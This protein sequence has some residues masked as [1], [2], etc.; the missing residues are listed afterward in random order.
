MRRLWPCWPGLLALLG[1]TALA[2]VAGEEPA[3][4]QLDDLSVNARQ[5]PEKAGEVPIAISVIE[6]RQLDEAGLTR[7][8]ELPERVPGLS[9]AAPN[10]RQASYAIRGLGSS[11]Y[12]DGLDGSVGVFVDGVYLG[13]PGMSL[14]TLF[15]LERVEVLRGPQ[16]TLYGKNSTAGTLNLYSRLPTFHPEARGEVTMGEDGLRRYRGVLSGELMEG[17]LA[18]RLS[19]YDNQRDA[20]VENL[21]PGISA[22]DRDEQ[23]LRGQL[24]WQPDE[25]FSARLILD[26]DRRNENVALAASNYSQATVQRSAYLGYAL[27]PIDPYAREVDHDR[28]S[29]ADVR[30]NGMSL[31]L[32]RYWDDGTTLTSISA[33]RDWRYDTRLDADGTGLAVAAG[34]AEL[35]HWQFSQELRLA[36]SPHERLDYVAGLYYLRQNLARDTGVGFGRGAAA[37]FLGDRPELQLPPP[38]GPLPS[39]AIPA[40]LLDGAQQHFD[41][42]QRSDSRALFGQLT[43]H[44]T[45]RLAVTPGLRYTHERKRAWLSRTVSNLAPLL[46]NPLDPLDPLWQWGGPLLRQVALGGDYYRR[47]SIEEHDLSGHLSVSYR[48]SDDLL[49]YASWSRGYKAGGINLD[50]TSRYAQPTFDAER[51]ISLEVGF[52]RAFWRDRAWLD[53]ALY[54]TDVDGYQ[55]LTNSRPANELAPPLR[56]NLINV[57]KVRL[58]GV[59]LDGRLRAS[60]QVELRLGVAYSDARYQDFPN[61][62]CAP[63]SQSWTCDLSGQRLFNAPRW[64]VTAGLDYRQPLEQGLALFAGLD[65]NLRSASQGTLE[66]GAGSRQPTYALTHLRFGLGRSDGGWELE[67]W[68]RNLFDRQ[69][70]TAVRG[71]LGSGDYGVVVGEARQLGITLRVAY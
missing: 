46:S 13:R 23:G 21:H 64:G 35:E 3:L 43:W 19:G 37:F 16:G 63:Q 69:Y 18:G 28:E 61:A 15:D 10:A 2:Q 24:L 57:G 26:H 39:N 8:S 44:L 48:F 62:P 59:E 45:P 68:V 38:F 55:A 42:E 12:N 70:I 53:L 7:A 67:L 29:V 22:R 36:G 27:P 11:G 34:R 51:A 56:D 60:E 5:R 66:G 40:S 17:V 14:G 32:N 47:D 25:T 71:Q 54:Q 31:E 65:Y 33:Y 20:L 50:V 30:Q 58:R 4:L 49:G 9:L 6:G 1:G 52:K 41:S